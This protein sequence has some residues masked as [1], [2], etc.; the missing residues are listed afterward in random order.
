MSG[1][2]SRVKGHAFERDMAK[3]WRDLGFNCVTS[4]AESK[5]LD[6]AGIDLVLDAPFD[7]QC[8]ANEKL[9]PPHKVLGEIEDRPG[10][11]RVLFHKLNRSGV[12]VSMTLEDFGELIQMLKTEGIL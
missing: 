7:V 5:R 8:K 10:R 6:A 1:K 3:W 2:R 9:G 4:R 12:C 11:Y